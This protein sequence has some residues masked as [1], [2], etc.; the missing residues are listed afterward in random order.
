LTVFKYAFMRG[1]KSPMSI[2]VN[3]AIPLFLLIFLYDT[4]D[5][6]EAAVGGNQNRTL[7]FI[8]M[9]VMYG[10]FV[11]ARSIQIDKRDGTVV[12]ILAGPITMRAYLIQNFLS[13]MIP[14]T[15]LSLIIGAIGLIQHNWT[16][17]YAGGVVLIYFFLSATSIGLSFVWSCLFKDKE[18]STA[19]LSVLITFVATLG[20]LMIPLRF[21]PDALQFIGA[22]FPAYWAARGLESLMDYGMN[23]Q[24]WL[25]ILA[26]FLFTVA[27]IL[28]GGRRRIV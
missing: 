20:G 18:T 9:L 17:E 12:R 28:Y 11:M 3:I 10:A 27:Y 22:L 6:L 24:F 8:G 19:V 5:P 13:S 16:I 26:M 15:V 25:G 21:L 2:I 1:I 14:M 4:Q 23:T 7:F